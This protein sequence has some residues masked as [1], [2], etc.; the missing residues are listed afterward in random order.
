MATTNSLYATRRGRRWLGLDPHR[1]G[2]FHRRAG[3]RDGLVA[4]DRSGDVDAVRAPVC[5][6]GRTSDAGAGTGLP[7]VSTGRPDGQ[8]TARDRRSSQGTQ[9]KAAL[10]L[11]FSLWS[12]G[13]S[14]SRPLPCERGSEVSDA[15]VEVPSGLLSAQLA[16]LIICR[17]LRAYGRSMWTLCGLIGPCLSFGRKVSPSEAIP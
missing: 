6:P 14:N 3:G 13:D 17:C 15:G 7:D 12:G 5:G 2:N 16:L 10:D 1:R 8:M 9:R 4:L 11:H